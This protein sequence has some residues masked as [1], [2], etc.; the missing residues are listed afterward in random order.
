MAKERVYRHD[1]RCPRCGSNWMRKDGHSRGKQVYACGDC[2]R[3]H[4]AGGKF[5]HFSDAAKDMAIACTRT[6][7]A[8]LR[9]RGRWARA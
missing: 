2:K 8:C 6:G 9:L 4:V 1:I 3:K 7:L 5:H